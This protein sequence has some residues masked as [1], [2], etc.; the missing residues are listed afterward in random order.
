[1][2]FLQLLPTA[3]AGRVDIN[4]LPDDH[5]LLY[6]FNFDRQVTSVSSCVLQVA[7]RH[8]CI[9]KLSRPETCLRSWDTRRAHGYLATLANYYRE[10]VR[11]AHA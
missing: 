11:F 10:Y 6:I 8:F 4:M 2:L 9:A 3:G 1:M 5:V 7:I